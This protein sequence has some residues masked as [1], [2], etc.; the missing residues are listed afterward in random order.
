MGKI[1]VTGASGQLGRELQ[2]AVAAA[3]N[4][5][6]PGALPGELLET[7]S[8]ELSRI[9]PPAAAITDFEFVFLTREDLPLNDPGKIRR[10]FEQ[11]HPVCCI[12]CAAYTAVDKAESEKDLAFLINGEAVGVLAATCKLFDTRLIHISTD[13]VFDG[14]SATPLKE[15]EATG[16]V[17]VYG[18]SKL[19][20]EQLALENNDMTVIIRTAWVY[21]SYGNNFVKTMIRLMRE[22]ESIGVINDQI[23]TPTY[24]ADLA[25]VILKIA[26][27]PVFVPGIYHYS[28]EGRI[29]WYDFA[30]AIKA[31]TGSP[32]QVNPIPS[33]QYPTPARRPHYSLLDKSLIKKTY[34]ITVPDWKTSLALCLERIARG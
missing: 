1:L 27:G 18:A 14:Q 13:Y 26:C 7:L 28:N 21:S 6:P 34:G 31:L 23:G 20:G 29:S 11:Q 22:R 32:C 17:N 15:G 24:A 25:M 5:L 19:L 30:V 12:H 2:Q 8:G 9:L 4:G 3:G 33:S 10:L 16:P